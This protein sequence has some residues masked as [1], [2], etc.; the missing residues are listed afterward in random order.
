MHISYDSTRWAAHY[1]HLQQQTAP[2]AGT[3]SSQPEPCSSSCPHHYQPL[4]D[5]ADVVQQCCW[6]GMVFLTLEVGDDG[7]R[8][9][10]DASGLGDILFLGLQTQPTRR[11]TAKDVVNHVVYLALCTPPPCTVEGILMEGSTV[12]PNPLQLPS[13]QLEGPQYQQSIPGAAP[14]HADSRS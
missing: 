2:L 3:A 11:N 6:D 1:T 12:H 14:S 8:V 4:Q 7:N 9:L 10:G 5:A 13:M